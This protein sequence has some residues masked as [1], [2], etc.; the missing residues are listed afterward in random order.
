MIRVVDL[1]I[2]KNL[3]GTGLPF[4]MYDPVNSAWM[5]LKAL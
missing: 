4:P 3:I 5:S 1:G 2:R